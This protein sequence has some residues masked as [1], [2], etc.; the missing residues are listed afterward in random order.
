MGDT[1]VF[2][3]TREVGRSRLQATSS[4]SSSQNGSRKSPHHRIS[5]ILRLR[6]L[7]LNRAK[8]TTAS[9]LSDSL[10]ESANNALII[11]GGGKA[12][13]NRTNSNS[14][15]STSDL[16]RNNSTNSYQS[17]RSNMTAMTTLSSA[18]MSSRKTDKLRT[19]RIS[20][21]EEELSDGQLGINE[22]ELNSMNKHIPALRSHGKSATFRQHYYPEGGW[23]WVITFCTFLVNIFTT[24]L[25]LSFSI[26]YLEIIRYCN[27][28]KN[29]NKISVVWIGSTN[30]AVSHLMSPLLVALC[31]RKSTRLT[32]VVGG[33]VMALSLLFASFA[34]HFDQILLSYGV[35]F[36][37]G[38]AMVRDTSSLM[39]GQYFK[40]RR[41]L[42]ETLSSMGTGF[43]IAIFSNVYQVGL[44]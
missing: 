20:R 11:N 43:G 21:Y 35:L 36:G 19:P 2:I 16:Y 14:I 8:T 24:G 7:R 10:S 6:R 23:G 38:C 17:A 41:E 39:L 34:K 15:M 18:S 40:R 31:R 9:S 44:G 22:K 13:A 28:D 1:H 3:G 26:L 5:D 30:L 37:I 25:Q 27:D 29:L 12:A 4:S 33:L 42:V 32:A